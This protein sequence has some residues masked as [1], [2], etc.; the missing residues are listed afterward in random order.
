MEGKELFPNTGFSIRCYGC[1]PVVSVLAFLGCLNRLSTL[2]RASK[3][4]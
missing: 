1:L 2:I 3:P 4:P